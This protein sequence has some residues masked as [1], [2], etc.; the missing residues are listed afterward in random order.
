VSDWRLRRSIS[1][2]RIDAGDDVLVLDVR[3]PNE[4]RSTGFPVRC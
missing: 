4:Y 3:E 1:K 2:K